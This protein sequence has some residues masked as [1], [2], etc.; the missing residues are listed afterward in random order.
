MVD[1]GA[2]PELRELRQR[3][4]QVDEE[5]VRAIARR[6]EAVGL[7]AQAKA[8]RAEGIRD[9][10]RE[11]EVLA[12]VEGIARSLGI[13]A[14]LAR[15]VFSELIVHSL[16]RQATS[17]SGAPEAGR[18]ITVA[19]QG[20]PLTYSHLAAQKYLGERADAGLFVG[21][22]SFKAVVDQLVSG[23]ADLAF[24]PIENTAAGSINQVYDI[25]REHDV[26]IVGEE[27]FK[28]DLCLAGTVDVPLSAIR[29]VI[30]HPLALDQ[31]SAFIDALPHVRPVPDGDTAEAARLVAEAKDPTQA[32]ITSPEAAAAHG[33][34][35]LRRGIGN[36]EDVLMRYVALARMPAPVDRRVPCKTS[37]ILSTSHE[38]GA[39]VRCLQ[40]I[41]DYGLSMTKIESRP[42][43]NRAWEYMFFVDFEGNS[44][45]PRAVAAIEQLRAQTLFLKVLGC[46][47]AKATPTAAHSTTVTHDGPPASDGTEVKAPPRPAAG[48]PVEPPR[49]IPPAARSKHYKLADR[50]SRAEDTVV[51]VGDLLIGGDGFTV[52][53]GPCAVESA[54]QIARAAKFV[55]EHGAHV[56]R[57]GVF[58]PRTS[59]YAFQGLGY[60]GLELLSSA[61]RAAGLPIVTEVMAPE[62]V[63]AMAEKADILQIGARNMQNFDLLR[64][65][66]KVDR[67]VLL[68]RGLS[69]TIE[70]WLA[71]AEYIL[72]QGNSQVMLC[73][74]GIR[75][76]ESATRNTL[77]LSAV[78]VL[79]ERTHLPVIVDPSHG[80]GKRSYVAPMAY[81]A[82]ACGAHGLLI[83]VHPEPERALSD[84][85]QSLTFAEFATLMDGLGRQRT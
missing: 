62:Q 45:D 32:A 85:D 71:A 68:K 74:R 22:P 38:H 16:T 18:T 80:T 37:L 1:E 73:E 42:R 79:R 59:P 44:G 51:R 61:G 81:A 55:R 83:E 76:F 8:G 67:P 75:T 10:E 64:A 78:V 52:M 82:R 21:L 28:L 14:P 49:P 58:K 25:L 29:R 50:A 39:L 63:R 11:Q 43:P 34:N 4:D 70:E 66:G 65:V 23:A 47:P 26:H 3:L 84:G 57:G 40:V 53:A 77:D 33:L 6:L 27:T 46:Y 54:D 15:K 56:L 20:A 60:D 13:S 17:L 41:A 7:I 31:C 72:A 2:S 12:R 19:Y 69:S 35:I 48:I 36:Q 24:L 30:S 9:P 5:I